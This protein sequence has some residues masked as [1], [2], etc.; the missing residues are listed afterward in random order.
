[1]KTRKGRTYQARACVV[2]LPLGVLKAGDV[3][4][5]PAL[6][7]KKAAIASL[8]LGYVTRVVLRFKKRFWPNHFGFLHT[9]DEWLPTW[10]TNEDPL[11][12]TGWA[13]GPRGERTSQMTEKA[14]RERAIHVLSKIFSQ[15][16]T[17]VG[18]GLLEFHFH[19]WNRDP[20]ARMAYSYVGVNQIAASREL[21]LPLASTLFFAGEATSLD[22][23]QGTVHGALA[24]GLRAAEEVDGW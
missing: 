10:W 7:E 20:Y 19:N 17:R 2:T 12:L 11:S 21:A 1:M 5:K 3:E 9:G 13:G 6:R 18:T 15:N 24:T 8:E 22:F 23:Q 14:L 4:F 16:Q